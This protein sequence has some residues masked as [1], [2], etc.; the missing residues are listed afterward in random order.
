MNHVSKTATIILFVLMVWTGLSQAQEASK[1]KS[2]DTAVSEILAIA[3]ADSLVEKEGNTL[4]LPVLGYTPDTSVMLGAAV[5]KFFY[6]EHQEPGARPSVFSPTF[7]YTLNSQIMVF[8]GTDLNWGEGKWHSKFGPSYIKFPDQFYGIGR[9][10]SLDDEEDYTPERV[11]FKGM[12]ERETWGYKV[13][14]GYKGNL[15]HLDR[16]DH[17]D[18]KEK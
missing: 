10:V 11:A 15:D 17:V 18:R 1:D 2:Y 6:L 13:S 12:V 14:K 16:P 9:D 7:I 5:L 8:L 4:I 3:A